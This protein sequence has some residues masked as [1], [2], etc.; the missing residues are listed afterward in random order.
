LFRVATNADDARK[1]ATREKA[2]E[3]LKRIRAGEDF[4]ALAAA[5]SD[6]DSS[7]A[8]GGDRGFSTRGIIIT[9]NDDPFGNVAFAMSN[10]GEI[11]NVVETQDGYHII[12]LT[13]LERARRKTFDEVK[14][15]LIEDF[16]FR[17][18]GDFW[19]QFGG[20]LRAKA[21]IELTPEG[22]AR[23]AQAEKRQQ[24]F[25]EK[26]EKL[27]AQEQE[28]AKRLSATPQQQLESA[29]HSPAK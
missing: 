13:G 24:E 2:Q 3:I 19:A 16:K 20:K 28:K 18:I 1:L 23:Q 15:Q 4:A 7:K 22:K 8:R 25:N 14:R 29:A 12:K 10:I 27:I 11:S 5:Y 26:I 21:E 17:E 9:P 6:D